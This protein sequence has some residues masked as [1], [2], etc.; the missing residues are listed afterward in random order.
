MRQIL[1]SIA[2]VAIGGAVGS[3]ARWF[4]GLRLNALFS[5]FALGTLAANLLAGYLIGIAIGIFIRYPA[6]APE[7]RLFIITGLLG[8]LSTFSSFSAESLSLLQQAHLG[9]FTL[10]LLLHVFGSLALTLAGM[11]TAALFG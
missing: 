4:L 8:G 7:W 3:V 1:L 9:E 6:I 2:V 5:G 11:M 10:H